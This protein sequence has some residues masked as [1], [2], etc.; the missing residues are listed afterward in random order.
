[1]IDLVGPD[2]QF[3]VL[4]DCGGFFGWTSF[5]SWEPTGEPDVVLSPE[6]IALRQDLSP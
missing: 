6:Y 5:G 2:E 4:T 3:W 1:M